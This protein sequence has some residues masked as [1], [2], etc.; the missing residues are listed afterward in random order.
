MILLGIY[1]TEATALTFFSQF[2]EPQKKE[3]RATVEIIVPLFIVSKE[4]GNPNEN[5]YA[6][7]SPLYTKT[8][9]YKPL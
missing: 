3:N 6:V 5:K 7:L 1:F 9:K 8:G 2:N 4:Y